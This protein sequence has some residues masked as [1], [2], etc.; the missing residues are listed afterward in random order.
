M[1]NRILQKI[2]AYLLNEKLGLYVLS[3][4]CIG[5]WIFAFFFT[6]YFPDIAQYFVDSHRQFPSF[7]VWDYHSRNPLFS[8]ILLILLLYG[9]LFISILLLLYYI[10]NIDSEFNPDLSLKDI[11]LNLIAWL[12]LMV[13]L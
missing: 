11:L 7:K 2:N 9:S 13:S 10:L 6:E 1:N 3:F 4:Y 8:K 5:V 12:L